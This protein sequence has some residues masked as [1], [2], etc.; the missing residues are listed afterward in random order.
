[1]LRTLSQS[2]SFTQTIESYVFQGLQILGGGL[3]LALCSQIR[4]PLP[5]TLV[6]LTFQ[7]AIVLLLGAFFGSRKGSLMVLTYLVQIIA[8][9][10]VLGGGIADS[11]AL[12]GPKGGYLVGFILQAYL[13]GWFVERLSNHQ[14]RS[15]LLGGFFAC[16]LQL[17]LGVCWLS[18]FVGWKSAPMMG[19]YP[20]IP[21]E[22]LKVLLV[23]ALLKKS[24]PESFS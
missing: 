8:G 6:P 12:L 10:P 17:G 5:F 11:Y 20:F 18:Q 23:T 16:A 19:L 3:F 1:M 13:M 7:T 24:L 21:G 15:I 14:N 9:L 4:F 22:I 2:Y